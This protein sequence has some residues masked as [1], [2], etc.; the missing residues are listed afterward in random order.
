M[1]EIYNGD[2]KD[3]NTENWEDFSLLGAEMSSLLYP[4]TQLGHSVT[5]TGVHHHSQ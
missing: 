3:R 1:E 4:E 2:G 5:T